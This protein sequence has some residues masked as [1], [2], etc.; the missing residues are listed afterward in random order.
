MRTITVLHILRKSEQP[1]LLGIFT[2]ESL[3]QPIQQHFES[4]LRILVQSGRESGQ[5]SGELLRGG[6]LTLQKLL[7]GHGLSD[8]QVYKIQRFYLTAQSLMVEQYLLV[9][10]VGQEQLLLQGIANLFLALATDYLRPLHQGLPLSEECEELVVADFVEASHLLEP[11]SHCYELHR[12]GVQEF[13][14]S[15]ATESVVVANVLPIDLAVRNHVHIVVVVGLPP[16]EVDELF[17]HELFL[18]HHAEEQS[19]IG[20]L[21]ESLHVAF[22]L[23]DDRCDQFFAG[24][25]VFPHGVLARFL[26]LFF[27]L[28][29][30]T[31]SDGLPC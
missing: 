16:D 26:Y 30:A 5:I 7:L 11:V 2:L 22:G 29:E 31:A 6:I 10:R 3:L 25:A 27:F 19:E 1:L 8:M 21:V 24:T 18:A 13:A 20:V 12:F 14:Y 28:A 9:H 4:H 17:S 23:F 15:L